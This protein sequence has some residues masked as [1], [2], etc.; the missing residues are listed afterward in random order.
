M[1]RLEASPTAVADAA[2]LLGVPLTAADDELRAAYL[3]QVQLNPPDREPELFER[4]RDAHDLLRNPT[5]RAR[6]VLQSPP[7]KPLADVLAGTKPSRRFVGSAPW[8]AVLKE[9]RS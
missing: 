2:A 6:Q 8:L 4:I 5:V 1:P 3:K 7:A 9:T